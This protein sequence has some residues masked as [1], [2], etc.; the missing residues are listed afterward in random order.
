MAAKY[1]RIS[2]LPDFAGELLNGVYHLKQD[3]Y[4]ETKWAKDGGALDEVPV[5]VDSSNEHGFWLISFMG[6]YVMRAEQ[7]S[8]GALPTEWF[9]WGSC[10]PVEGMVLEEYQRN[11]DGAP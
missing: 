1:L 6:E 7:T 2:G 9:F 5:I 3:F 8:G 10:E 4:F 11:G